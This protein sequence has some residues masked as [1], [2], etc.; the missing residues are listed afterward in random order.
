MKLITAVIRPECFPQTKEA[1][2]D[3]GIHGMTISDAAGYGA[4]HGHREDYHGHR[5]VYRGASYTVALL[6]KIRVEI[7]A[8]DSQTPRIVQVIV[9]AARTEVPGDGKVWVLPVEEAV[10]VR[11]GERDDAALT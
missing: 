4:Q 6:Q 3:F 1:L 2:E 5:E 8:E 11:T 7:L 9:D 10:R